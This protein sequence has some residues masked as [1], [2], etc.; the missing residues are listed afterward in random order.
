MSVKDMRYNRDYSVD[1]IQADELMI[2]NILRV[3]DNKNVLS[4]MDEY[5]YKLLLQVVKNHV[6]LKASMALE[7]QQYILNQEGSK[8]NV[9]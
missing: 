3:L 5:E 8:S 6:V 2:A 1:A 9:R 7:E 4:I